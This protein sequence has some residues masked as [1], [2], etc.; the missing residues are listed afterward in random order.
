ME[1]VVDPNILVSFLTLAFLEI[2]LGID[3][4]IFI[5][6]I[7][8]K[9][10]EHLQPRARFIGLAGALVMRIALLFSIVWV[11]S[12]T[13]PVFEIG[14]YSVS[15]RDLILIGGGMFLLAKAT[16]EI[17]ETIE[18]E[19]E[20]DHLAGK[21]I[22]GLVI[23]QIIALDVVF[24]F[25]SVITAVGLTEN[26]GVM[27][28]AVSLAIVIMMAAAGPVSGFIERHPTTKMLALSFLLLIGMALVAEGLHFHVPRG[29]L[30][31][32][33][34]FSLLVEGL[35]LWAKKVRRN[36]R[37]RRLAAVAASEES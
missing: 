31:F 23:L 35:N 13:R 22:F 27:I 20:D 9:L 1:Q 28:A 11:I 14:G 36:R 5:S 2:V 26:V 33:I 19:E 8:G 34:G 25:D 3:N 15:W 7:A 32:A 30:Y 6:V 21:A 37:L 4:V 29:Y 24:S 12:L 18:G 10:P 16:M 17:H